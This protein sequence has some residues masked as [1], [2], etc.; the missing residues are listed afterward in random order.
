MELNENPGLVSQGPIKKPCLE[1]NN[2]T[3]EFVT[4]NQSQ[5]LHF[6]ICLGSSVAFV[7]AFYGI[8]WF[9]L[10]PF[11]MG[12]VSSPVLM[13]TSISSQSKVFNLQPQISTHSKLE[14]GSS[15]SLSQSSTNLLQPQENK[16]ENKKLSRIQ[17]IQSKAIVGETDPGQFVPVIIEAWKDYFK[18]KIPM[19]DVN[20]G[21]KNYEILDDF[22]N[23]VKEMADCKRTH[24]EDCHDTES[25]LIYFSNYGNI[26]D[27]TKLSRYQKNIIKDQ[28]SV[29]Y[30]LVKTD[31]RQNDSGFNRL[32]HSL[33]DSSHL[34]LM[35]GE[36][37]GD[38]SIYKEDRSII[39]ERSF[40]KKVYP[41]LKKCLAETLKCLR[42]DFTVFPNGL[43]PQVCA[44]A[45]RFFRIQ[46][47]KTREI[48]RHYLNLP[49][50]TKY[51]YPFL[52]GLRDL[53]TQNS[54]TLAEKASQE[55]IALIKKETLIASFNSIHAGQPTYQDRYKKL[56]GRDDSISYA[57]NQSAVSHNKPQSAVSHNKP[58]L[59]VSHNKHQMAAVPDAYHTPTTQIDETGYLT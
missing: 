34:N 25:G 35:L 32:K 48:F 13:T 9:Y 52:Y 46:Y 31:F 59:A 12:K 43:T 21:I 3:K 29:S 33:S 22:A 55:A 47:D 58:Q 5:L 36:R 26:E 40:E 18:K 42:Q 39:F 45:H 44:Y 7:A 17:V 23:H 57:K 41:F 27:S 37:E 30:L 11:G 10:V 49:Y 2:E 8:Y 6:L 56:T 16:K 38:I 53:N 28:M 1:L 50:E 51:K 15:H 54:V 24:T 14:F 20:K 19:T 4:Q